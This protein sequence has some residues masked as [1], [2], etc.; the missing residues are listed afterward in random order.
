MQNLLASR[1]RGPV[2]EECPVSAD[3][4]AKKQGSE[5]FFNRSI[6]KIQNRLALSQA[7]IS[8]KKFQ[9]EPNLVMQSL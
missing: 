9:Q 7:W 6:W 5:F 1:K 3:Q 8:L 4:H 2:P